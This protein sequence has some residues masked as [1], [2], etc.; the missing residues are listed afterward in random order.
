MN[1]SVRA[2]SDHGHEL[3][4]EIVAGVVASVQAEMSGKPASMVLEI[5]RATMA[6]R[7]PGIAVDDEELRE[8]AARISVG[9]SGASAPHERRTTSQANPSDAVTDTAIPVTS[10]G[11]SGPEVR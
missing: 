1:T 9:L 8:A 5:L 2:D 6:R 3:V 4:D 11:L 10:I 7:L